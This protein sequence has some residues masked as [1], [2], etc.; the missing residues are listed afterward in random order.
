MGARVAAL[1]EESM[2]KITLLTIAALIAALTS[3]VVEARPAPL[4]TAFTYQG[5]LTQNG[6]L[7]SGLYDLRFRLYDAAAAGSQIGATYCANDV[8]VTG[9]LFTVSLDFGAQFAG[10]QR[11]LEI[12]VRANTGLD[13]TNTTGFTLLGSRQALTG[14]PCALFALSAATAGTATSAATAANATALNGQ[15]ASFYQNA[16]NLNTGTIGSAL[17]SGAYSN[18]L[19]LSNGSNS[20]TG[21]GLGLVSLNATNISFGI[22]A[23]SHLSSNI[24][25]LNVANAFGNFTNTFAGSVGIGTTNPSNRLTVSNET[26]NNSTVAIDS[27]A[28]AAQFSTLRLNDRGTAYWSVSKNPSNDFVIRETGVPADRLYIAQGGNVG[29]GTSFPAQKLGVFAGAGTDGIY[30]ETSSTSGVAVTGSASAS[31]GSTYGVLGA[32]FSPSG[33]AVFGWATATSGTTYGG[34]FISDSPSGRAVYGEAT[35]FA[36]TNYGVYGKANIAAAGYAVYAN[37]DM[38]AS[39]TKPFR[40]DHPDDP[41]NKYLLHYAAESPEV[42]NFYRGTVRL[43]GAGEAVVEMPHYFARINKDPSYT[44]TAMGAAMPNLHIADEISEAALAA[45]G[46]CWF[47]IAGGAPGMKVSWRVEALRNDLWVQTR[48]APVE[49]DK[50]GPEKGTYQH[51]ELYGQ[52][53]EKGMNYDAMRAHRLAP[54]EQP[55]GK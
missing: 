43:D 3:K 52:P 32:S 15:A 19:T 48:G 16:S 38:G 27:G 34:Y 20:F 31:S 36:G 55:A 23:D 5:R 51:P 37:G 7:T 44:L 1:K 39:G 35:P 29:I 33:I 41:T 14:A 9:G 10:E 24:P 53:P 2:R 4:G 46:P 26:D 11:F 17:L 40:I 18:P 47:R 8:N 12:E 50:Q 21:S 28:T 42:I 45:G 6:N 13:C 54:P 22:L 49:V 25:R 30:G